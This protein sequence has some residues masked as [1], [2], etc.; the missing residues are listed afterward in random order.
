MKKKKVNKE[1]S[2]DGYLKA[3]FRRIW[4]WSP[5][6][7]KCL[8]GRNCEVCGRIA[9]KLFAD[10]IQPVVDPAKGFE[11]WQIYYERMFLGPLQRICKK[12]HSI[13]TKEENKLRRKKK[14]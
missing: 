6:R 9:K 13:K 7:K 12:C 3:Q 10:H 2:P 14:E 11:N 1:W 4:R 8:A 5:Q